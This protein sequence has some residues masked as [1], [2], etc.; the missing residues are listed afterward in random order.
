MVKN[1][2]LIVK[3]KEIL[4]LTRKTPGMFAYHRE[5]FLNRIATVLEILEIDFEITDFYAKHL[6]THGSIYLTL[7]DTFDDNWAHAVID[8]A[9]Q[10][11]ENIDE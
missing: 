7:S 10:M 1:E 3:A 2:S 11:I 4:A 5:S 8:D 6:G 9:F